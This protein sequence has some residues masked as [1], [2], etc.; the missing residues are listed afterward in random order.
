MTC[1]RRD[2]RGA[3]A[4]TLCA[5]L[6][7]TWRGHLAPA[8]FAGPA[9]APTPV[10]GA[11][12]RD[13]AA[14]PGREA[15]APAAG[16]PSSVERQIGVKHIFW[17]KGSAAWR[18]KYQIQN[19]PDR[20][21][22]KQTRFRPKDESPEQVEQ[23]RL[24]AVE[25]LRRL[26][27]EDRLGRIRSGRHSAERQSGVKHIHWDKCSAVWRIQYTIQNGP[28]QGRRKRPVFRPKDDSPE[29]V[30]QARLAAVEA[31]LRLEEEDQLGQA[32]A[33]SY[34]P[35]ERQSGVKHIRWDNRKTAWRIKYTMQNG[36][37]QGRRKQPV[38]HPYDESPEEVERA[39]LAAVEALRR[40]EEEDRVGRISSGRHSAVRQSGVKHILWDK[41]SAVWRIQYTMQNGP[42]QG[43]R[44]R[45]LFR[46][47]DDSPEEV[48]QAR[49]AAVEA[50][51]RLEEEDQLGQARAGS[52]SPTERQ[53]GVKHIRWDNRKTAWRIK[54]TIQNGPDQGRRKQPVFHPYDDSPEEVE[55]ARLAAVEALRRLEEEDR[56][57]RISS[58]RHRAERQSGV[59]HIS[60]D[61]CNAVWRIRYT[62][63]SGPDQGRRKR[64]VFRPKDESPEEV[65][66]ARLAAVEALRRLEDEDQLGQARAGRHSA[67]RQSALRRLQEE[68]R[69]LERSGSGRRSAGRQSGVQ[70]GSSKT[71][72]GADRG[73]GKQPACRPQD[74][75]PE[76]A[77]RAP[78]AAAEALRG[79]REVDGALEASASGGPC[80]GRGRREVPLLDGLF[81]VVGEAV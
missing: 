34:S 21:C 57:G 52:Y 70:H 41:G 78:L 64:P 8:A 68:D 23:A 45:P 44:K 11:P 49:L 1:R 36:P 25:A 4:A 69:A 59:K 50:L 40:L 9:A 76:E 42:D 79:L 58:G 71:T 27:D 22:I 12:L 33:G 80:A 81:L 29:E 24:A 73:T 5:A 32:R 47:K 60:W 37:D 63:Q 46:P 77:E 31:L 2:R 55:R 18:I 26:E 6:G 62:M 35:A 39:R 16:H 51:L 43:R 30:E 48:E 75:S 14:S 38:F 72:S 10:R 17:D 61:K 20:G 67:E 7:A 74:E 19:G 53:S 3:A 13:T 65:E 15:P 56:V 66:Q 54:Y 28:D